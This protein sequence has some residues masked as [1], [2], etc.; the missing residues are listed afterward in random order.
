MIIIQRML[1]N[2]KRDVPHGSKPEMTAETRQIVFSR[3]IVLKE[4]GSKWQ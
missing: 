1:T 3:K 4:N 2:G